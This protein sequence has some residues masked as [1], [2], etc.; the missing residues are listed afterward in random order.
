MITPDPETRSLIR[1][2][3]RVH[4]TRMLPD[5]D[6]QL[7]PS[8]YFLKALVQFWTRVSGSMRVSLDGIWIRKR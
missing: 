7:I 6:C 1:H 2:I 4:E 3:V 5:P 8:F